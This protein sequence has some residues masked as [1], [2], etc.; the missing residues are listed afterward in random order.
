[1][2]TETKEG[3][4]GSKLFSRFLKSHQIE[5]KQLLEDTTTEDYLPLVAELYPRAVAEYV[6]KLVE[7]A[8]QKIEKPD[9]FRADFRTS[10]RERFEEGKVTRNVAAWASDAGKKLGKLEN[11]PS[12]IGIAREYVRLLEASP[13]EH[14]TPQS[15]QRPPKLLDYLGDTSSPFGTG[16]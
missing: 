5:S 15:L 8:G 14:F 3:R 7:T 16:T 6:L 10:F 9:D 1:M 13:A 11:A 2:W 4:Q 12:K